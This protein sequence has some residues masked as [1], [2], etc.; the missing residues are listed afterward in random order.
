MDF[1]YSL[2]KRTL[3]WFKNVPHLPAGVRKWMGENVWWIVLALTI[4]S[5]IVALIAIPALFTLIAIGNSIGAAYYVEGAYSWWKVVTSLVSI[6]FTVVTI[7]ISAMA[8]Q[9]LRA[10]LK[11]GWVLLF[12]VWLVNIVSVVVGA[13]LSLTVLGFFMSIL[14]GAIGA[15]I[16]GYLLFEIHDQFAHEAKVV[17]GTKKS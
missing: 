5:V 6:A 2:E 17:R 12:T 14:F 3:G 7:V 10:K 11:K 1:L 8:I 16:S 4:L 15:A 13:I 9:P